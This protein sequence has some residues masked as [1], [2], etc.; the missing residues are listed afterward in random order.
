MGLGKNRAVN[1]GRSVLLTEEGIVLTLLNL[2][3]VH[4]KQSDG[5]VHLGYTELVIRLSRI[6]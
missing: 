2:C 3:R 4:G 6:G 1:D 5:L